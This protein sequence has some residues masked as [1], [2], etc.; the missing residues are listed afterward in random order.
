MG[1][2]YEPFEGMVLTD[3]F[4]SSEAG[5]SMDEVFFPQNNERLVRQKHADITV[6]MANPPYSVG[7][8][9]EN[10]DNRNLSYPTLDA[11]D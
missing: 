10:D 7:Q 6:I 11:A 4:Q 3:T 5:D 2:E 8:M 9:S 1:G